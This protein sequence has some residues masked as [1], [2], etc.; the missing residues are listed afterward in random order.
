[1]V[2]TILKKLSVLNI[3]ALIYSKYS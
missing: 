3:K 2:T 1:V